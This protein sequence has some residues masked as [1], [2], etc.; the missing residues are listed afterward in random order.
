M[1]K[2]CF[3]DVGN[4]LVSKSHGYGLSPKLRR[5][6]L[7]LKRA[8]VSIGVM[9]I[10]TLE[11]VKEDLFDVDFDFYILLDGSLVYDGG[12]KVIDAPLK[13]LGENWLAYYSEGGVYARNEETRDE[14]TRRGF[15]TTGVAS[16]PKKAY[17]FVAN[18]DASLKD[19]RKVHW[20]DSRLNTYFKEGTS[21][22]EA[23]ALLARAHGWKKEE[24]L[25]FGDGPNDLEVAKSVGK[26]IALAGCPVPLGEE[27]AFQTDFAWKEGVSNA[28]RLLNLLP[29]NYV[30]FRE[31]SSGEV[32]GV[33]T[34]AKYLEEHWNKKGNLFIITHKD[35]KNVIDYENDGENHLYEEL[36]SLL[37]NRSV[38]VFFNSGHWIEEM[39][40]IRKAFPQATFFYR[41]GGNEI[42]SAPLKDMS[43]PFKERQKYWADALNRNLDY[44]IT[45]SYFTDRRLLDLGIKPS[46]LKRMSGGVPLARIKELKEKKP[47]L[48]KSLFPSDRIHLL[49]ASRFV[50]YKRMPLLLGAF[51]LLDERYDLTLIG[52]GPEYEELYERYK[53]DKRIRF[54]GKLPHE[55]VL[56]YVVGCDIYVQCS[57]NP[58]YQV[59]GGSYVH[60]EGMGRTILEAICSSTYVVATSSGAFPEFI[61][62]KRGVIVNDKPE[63]IAEAI[64]K[65]T[66][67]SLKPKG[68][69][70]YDFERIFARY[71]SLCCPKKRIALIS[72]KFTDVPDGGGS[73]M[74]DTLINALGKHAELDFFCLRTPREELKKNGLLHA[75]CFLPNPN[76]EDG[77]FESRL[78]CIPY[79]QEK[80]NPLLRDYDEIVVVHASKAFGLDEKNLKKATLFPMFLTKDY[81]RSGEKPPKRYLEEEKRVLSG[82][83]RVISPCQNDKEEIVSSYQIDP[84]K[85]TVIPRGVDPCFYE[86]HTYVSKDD[87]HLKM[88]LVA[89]IKK[90]KNLKEAISIA[91]KTNERGINVSLSICGAIDDRDLFTWLEGEMKRLPWLHY[92]GSLS[93]EKLKEK[94]NES[95]LL[96]CSSYFETFGRCVYEAASSDLPSLISDRLDCFKGVFDSRNA[97][98]YKNEE[99][100]L[101][102]LNRYA[103]SSSLRENMAKEAK[104][105]SL[106]FTK[107]KEILRLRKIIFPKTGLFILGTR[108]E[109]IKMSP[110]IRE[111]KE[112]GIGITI[113][114]TYQ[115]Q[116]LASR[117]LQEEGLT[118][119][120]KDCLGEGNHKAK[121]LRFAKALEK[122]KQRFSFVAVQG[123]TLSSLAG[124]Y[125]A[126]RTNT[127]L[128]YLE[129]GMRSFDETSPYP[130]EGIRK[131]ISKIASLNFAPSKKE[132]ENLEKEATRGIYLTGNTFQDSLLNS[133]LSVTEG[134]EVL[135]TLHRRENLS[136][137]PL[138]FLELRDLCFT[139]PELTFLFPVHPN[140]KLEKVTS[141]LKG[142]PNL[143]LCPPLDPRDFLKRLFSSKMVITDSGGV[144]EEARYLG[145]KCLVIR[146]A[147]ERGQEN[148]LSPDSKGLKAC[149]ET[150]LLEDDHKPDYRYGKESGAKTIANIIEEELY[151]KD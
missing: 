142:I 1:I 49:C 51:S 74:V 141:I 57:G 94:M 114:D 7:D 33:E 45:N 122:D 138:I 37:K 32:G 145:K 93:Q 43:M 19:I 108:P 39:D 124:A 78:S 69:E 127:P 134:N 88:L 5:D 67:Q 15:A 27:A 23:I 81:L 82:V 6:L 13:E 59:P 84:N 31:N 75:Y 140:P 139:H 50:P 89:N 90:Q 4:T 46:L 115:H 22:G 77:K 8:G 112:K 47:E 85:I 116:G 14:L 66:Y 73:S 131:E 133:G 135:I 44:L 130:E 35:G 132:V 103:S 95:D 2:A 83:K 3:F 110:V 53:D 137:L 54:L 26:F 79:Y 109:A 117:I 102:F 80:L 41:T 65:A 118:A 36:P 58:V 146:K 70:Q 24:I 21:K 107:E 25:A 63:D 121:A 149:F 106:E 105:R 144:E 52:D 62:G 10:R 56:P 126:L 76:R 100:V 64:R 120:K 111:L 98:F 17:G 129:S 68:F 60:C 30:L 91:G 61:K 148:L 34:H 38:V 101:S 87:G 11:M 42:P 143:T 96:I 92:E 12:K 147:S 123:D 72:S 150:L 113:Y 125:Y 97:Y 119:E 128:Y 29:I 20:G 48:R 16:T 40:E 151:E 86:G 71:D 18:E 99:D 9:S 28:I 104:E 55:D 136:H